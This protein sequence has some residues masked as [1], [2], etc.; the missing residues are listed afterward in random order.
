MLIIS[1]V[2]ED[3]FPVITLCGILLQNAL[4]VDSMLHA[5]LFPEFISNY[6]EAK[7]R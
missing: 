2:E 7:V 3:V 1:L 4:W 6:K 5:E